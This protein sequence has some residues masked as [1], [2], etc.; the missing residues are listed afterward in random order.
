MESL[1]DLKKE[2]TAWFDERI[3]H[4]VKTAVDQANKDLMADLD[5]RFGNLEKGLNDLGVMTSAVSRDVGG[6]SDSVA[7]MVESVVAIP[8]QMAEAVTKAIGGFNPFHLP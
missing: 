4:A 1:A 7:R 6:V 2:L 8:E 3:D 5:S